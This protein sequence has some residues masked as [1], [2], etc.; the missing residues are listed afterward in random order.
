MSD[1]SLD[2][3]RSL[4]SYSVAAEFQNSVSFLDKKLVF[5]ACVSIFV[6]LL[7]AGGSYVS[8]YL[9]SQTVDWMWLL[10]VTQGSQRPRVQILPSQRMRKVELRKR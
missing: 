5:I 9:I 6:V 10:R 3:L 8:E 7:K 1:V 2:H 4:Q